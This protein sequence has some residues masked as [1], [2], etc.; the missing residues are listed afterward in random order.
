MTLL[1]RLLNA[2]KRD[3]RLPSRFLLGHA[4]R[5]MEFGLSCDVVA[6][7]IVDLVTARSKN[8]SA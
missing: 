2:A 3:Q 8:A 6:Q 1:A 5:N 7:L 4:L